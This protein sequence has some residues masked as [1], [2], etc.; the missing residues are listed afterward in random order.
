MSA[1]IEP[2]PFCGVAPV[3]TGSDE[4]GGYVYCDNAECGGGVEKAYERGEYA[5][6]IAAWNRRADAEELRL[7]RE[8]EAALVDACGAMHRAAECRDGAGAGVAAMWEQ[9]PSGTA[10]R[11]ALRKLDALREGVRGG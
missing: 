6:T 1:E 4:H 5:E 11:A 10:A 8:V 3:V 2:C 9:G 7:L